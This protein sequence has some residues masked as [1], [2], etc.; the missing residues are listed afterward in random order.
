MD[1]F[2]RLSIHVSSPVETLKVQTWINVQNKVSLLVHVEHSVI[3]KEVWN[4]LASLEGCSSHSDVDWLD[5]M[6][7]SFRFCLDFIWME[8]FWFVEIPWLLVALPH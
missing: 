3:S 7:R 5:V 8:K 1:F 4:M 6:L 2:M